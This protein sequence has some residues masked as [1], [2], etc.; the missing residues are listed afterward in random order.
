MDVKEGR[1]AEQQLMRYQ[2]GPDRG[3]MYFSFLLCLG[4][5]PEKFKKGSAPEYSLVSRE[6][7]RKWIILSAVA[8][9]VCKSDP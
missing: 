6:H 3:S 9:P 7:L 5:I 1:A 2:K 8:D 4:I